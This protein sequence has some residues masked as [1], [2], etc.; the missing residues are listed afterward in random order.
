[1]LQKLVRLFKLVNFSSFL[2]LIVHCSW[3]LKSSRGALME[4]PWGWKTNGWVGTTADTNLDKDCFV[5]TE[6]S[7]MSHWQHSILKTKIPVLSTGFTILIWDGYENLLVRNY[8][9]TKKSR[10][11]RNGHLLATAVLIKWFLDLNSA[12]RLSQ[13]GNKILLSLTPVTIISWF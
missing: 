9:N 12:K 2:H 7:V 4:K 3:K 8:R 13:T 10:I 5:I 11:L 1:M 6:I